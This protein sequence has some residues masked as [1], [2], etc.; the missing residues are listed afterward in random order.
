MLKKFADHTVC[1]SSIIGLSSEILKGLAEISGITVI[2]QNKMDCTYVSDNMFAVHTGNGGRR[3]FHVPPK[4][5]QKATELFTKREFKI[6]D[7]AFEYVFEPNS[8]ALF[9]ME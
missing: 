7:G 4:Y 8:T 6:Q 1:Y 2:N 9:F 3:T 5:T